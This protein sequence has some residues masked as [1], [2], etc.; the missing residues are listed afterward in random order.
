MILLKQSTGSMIGMITFA[1]CLVACSKLKYPT[2]FTPGLVSSK[3]GLEYNVVGGFEVRE[4]NQTPW[5]PNLVFVEGGRF[6]MGNFEEDL[7]HRRDN[8]ERAVTVPTFYLDETEVGNIHWLEYEYYIQMDSTEEFWR[9]NLPDTTVWARDLAFNDPYITNYYR[10]PA[11]RFFPVV[12][13]NWYQASNYCQWRTDVINYKLIEES[14]YFDEASD[15]P[16]ADMSNSR[17]PRKV[18]IEAGITLPNYRLPTEAEWEYAAKGLI[19][20]QY[21][22]EEQTHQRIYPWDGHLQRYPY[23]GPKTQGLMM[24]NFKRGRGDYA[25]IAGRLNDNAMITTHIYEYYPNILGLYNM[26]GNVNEWVYDVY[27]SNSFQDMDDLNP[28]RRDDVNDEAE[29]YD[30]TYSF[31]GN[32]RVYTAEE[33]VA[34]GIS[35]SSYNANQPPT[36]RLRVYKGGSWQDGPYWL[37]AGNRRYDFDDKTSS[38]IGFRCAMTRMGL[39]Y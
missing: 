31:I 8:I 2:S 17:N 37:G 10:N 22:N 35:R 19:D 23:G 24:A 18:P 16:F 36:K 21:M 32:E 9:T 3:T 26:A 28:V 5:G 15:D 39:N 1:L 13:V 11:F 38:A 20:V 12:G 29:N 33:A 25:G 34:V 7:L 6:V 14:G 27:R 4:Y 30:A